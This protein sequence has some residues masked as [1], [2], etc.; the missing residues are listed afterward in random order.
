MLCRCQTARR[1]VRAAVPA[2][3]GEPAA[4]LAAARLGAAGRVPGLRAALLRL[5]ARPHQLRQQAQR[6]R[7]C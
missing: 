2:D 5:P 7:F 4:G 6:S 3:D 1:A